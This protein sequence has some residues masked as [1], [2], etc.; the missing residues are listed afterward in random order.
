MGIVGVEPHQL[1]PTVGTTGSRS[2]D[3]L[4]PSPTIA[5]L[6]T[7]T[8]VDGSS[9]AMA[10]DS[11]PPISIDIDSPITNL[12]INTNIDVNTAS[13]INISIVVPTVID[14]TPPETDVGIAVP[15]YFECYSIIVVASTPVSSILNNPNATGRILLWGIT[16]EP[17]EITYQRQSAKKS[18]VLP[19]FI[20][21]WTK[22]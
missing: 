21:E 15:H 4:A 13:T 11:A 17:W 20:A 8:R 3:S 6:S 7:S 16:L 9:S 19:D 14:T 5:D 18:Q 2:M 10:V 1:V 12:D 22:A